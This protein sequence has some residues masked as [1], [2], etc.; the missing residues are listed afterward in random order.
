MSNKKSLKLFL[1]T[2]ALV[3][4][5]Q[6]YFTW[7][8]KNIEADAKIY[9]QGD[10]KKEKY[11]LDS[12]SDI[13]VLDLGIKE[14][15]YDE[16]K[17]HEI[18]LGLDLKGGINVLLEVSERDV[19]VALSRKSRDP[20]F[21]YAI[22]KATE[23][24]VESNKDYITL[25]YEEF[26]RKA[27]VDNSNVKLSNV[28]IFGNKNLRSKVSQDMTD[29]QVINVIRKETVGAIDRVFEVLR[30]RIDKFG[31]AQPNI[32]KLENSN[33]IL[34]ELPGAKDAE[35]IKKI[36]QSS[37]KLEF[38]EVF[39]NTEMFSYLVDV[40]K[41]LAEEEKQKKLVNKGDEEKEIVK[42]NNSEIDSLLGDKN[43]NNDEEN[44]NPLFEKL[45]VVQRR[46]SVLGYAKLKDVDKINSYLNRKDIKSLLPPNLKY[47]K[48][49]WDVKP[50]EGTKDVVGLYALISNRT[51]RAPLE[52]DVITDAEPGYSEGNRPDVSMTMNRRG[53]EIWKKLTTKNKGKYIAIVLDDYVYSAL[54]VENVIPNGRSVISGNFTTKETADLSN[55]LKAGKLIAP[56]K[57]VQAE[58]VGPSLGEES[59][60]KGMTSFIIALIIILMWMIT[61]FGKAG[62][63]SNVALIANVLFLFGVLASRGL[64]LTLPG[65]AG[66]V[67]TIGMAVDANVI[68][69]ERIKEELRKGKKKK[70]AIVDGYKYSYSSILDANITTFLT[71][72][73]LFSFGTGPIKGF[74]TTLIVGI[75]TSLISS[76]FITR[77][78]IEAQ[79]AKG[80]GIDFS[81]FIS[82]NLFTK[83]NINFLGKRKIAYIISFI[84]IVLS[85]FSLF[86][87]GLD[88]GV[89]FVGGRTFT[90]RYENPV[91]TKELSSNL[92]SMF[93]E[94]GNNIAPEIKIFGSPNQVKITTKYKI[95]DNSDGVD[96]EITKILYKGS[97][98]LIGGENYNDF[99]NGKNNK[100]IIESM[101]VG[102][103]VANDIKDAALVAI[104]LSLILIFMYI[105]IRFRRWQFSIGA[106]AA[107][108]HDVIIVMG[109]F[110]LLKNLMPFSLEINQA[111]YSCYIDSYRILFKRYCNYI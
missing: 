96:S 19:L 6:L 35:R 22:N 18:N 58:I 24:E 82:K 28:T 20:I 16:V 104:T 54:I 49:L 10:D 107:L 21:N 60:S 63:Y 46:G 13:K 25:F 5:Y 7:A 83:I 79:L 40:N 2:F 52:G 30:N 4:I 62:L 109:V 42:N 70:Q 97:K 111:F 57:I 67:L 8:G 1:I 9:A 27:E 53:A 66:I 81:T 108:F 17:N 39:Y 12:V 50:I 101:K 68:I 31:I 55:I 100:G 14:Y 91:N 80:R 3:S 56:A 61:Y 110:S 77:L 11:Y 90:V 64:V 98:E 93:I 45:E 74:A 87:R 78:F 48:F 75:I 95:N 105:L 85:L 32:Q 38:W 44:I 37:A 36:L 106:I 59:I 65:L 69:Y 72:V 71:G 73:I 86:T 15:T 43:I 47:V 41:K 89:D 34:V 103:S 29:E 76:I 23:L 88:K 102:P 94:D 84:F 92:T 51:D 99:V 26:K 33:R